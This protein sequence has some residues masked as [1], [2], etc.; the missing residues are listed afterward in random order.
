MKTV[1]TSLMRCAAAFWLVACGYLL[2]A[3][4]SPEKWIS[5]FN[6]KDLA[7]WTV[8][9]DAKFEVKEGTLHLA[10]GNGWLRY[11]KEQLKDFVIEFE[12]RALE[13]FYDSGLFFRCGLEGKPWPD[14]GYQLN[15]RYNAIGS[16]VKV[17]TTVVPSETPKKPVNKWVKLR[18]EVKGKKAKLAVDGEDT[19]DTDN[20]E[21]DRGWLGFQAENKAFEFRNIRLQVQ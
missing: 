3:A 13:D 12:W 18:F 7:G 4:D 17:K 8:M 14:T 16:L 20:L 2:P 21:F 1:Q 5:L 15:L 10:S 19:W 11:D 9:G 6:G